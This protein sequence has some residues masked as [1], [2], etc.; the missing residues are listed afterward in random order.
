MKKFLLAMS[1][2]LAL[3]VTTGCGVKAPD[4]EVAITLKNNLPLIVL[5]NVSL[6]NAEDDTS[7]DST[8]VAQIKS[9]K[10][11]TFFAPKN[12]KVYF[13]YEIVGETFKTK[14]FDADEDKT[15]KY[16]ELLIAN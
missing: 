14:T 12:A 5:D 15:V 16:S 9:F 2:V 10:K 6:Y 8:V 13:Q 1:I 4:G 7:T 11:A 3:F